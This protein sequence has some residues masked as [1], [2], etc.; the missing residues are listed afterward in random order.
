MFKLPAMED[1]VEVIVDQATVKNNSDPLIIH[2]KSK[3]TSAA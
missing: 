2:A 1:V 3:T